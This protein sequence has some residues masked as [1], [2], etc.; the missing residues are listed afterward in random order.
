MA[1]AL[2]IHCY[3]E[4]D[5]RFFTG[6]P[7][8]H[9]QGARL[10]RSRRRG[11][12]GRGAGANKGESNGTDCLHV[13]STEPRSVCK[14]PL[15]WAIYLLM[16]SETFMQVPTFETVVLDVPWT[17]AAE[18]G[19]GEMMDYSK[20]G[21]PHTYDEPNVSLSIYVGDI[22]VATVLRGMLQ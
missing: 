2:N 11:T 21:F 15:V 4:Y 7:S 6:T 17:K 13:A 3:G 22:F 12:G 20:E 19:L 14:S 16:K 10:A 1:A 9:A 18:V 8:Y 5:V